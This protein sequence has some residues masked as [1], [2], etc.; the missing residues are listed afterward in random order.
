MSTRIVTFSGTSQSANL[1][2]KPADI[3]VATD[4]DY[5]N[6]KYI[7]MTDENIS[8]S[9]PKEYAPFLQDGSTA[10]NQ[11]IKTDLKCKFAIKEI[12]N[13]D[14]LAL[15]FGVENIDTTIAGHERLMID[16]NNVSIP[17]NLF[18]IRSKFVDG[19]DFEACI[20]KGQVMNPEDLPMGAATGATD[21]AN[22]GIEVEA[23]IDNDRVGNNLGYIDIALA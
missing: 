22:V 7:G 1:L 17:D 23:I 21:Y 10:F 19:R 11:V 5:A 18:V 2:I 13:I 15:A 6:A 16:S 12:G 20:W 8:V 9:I 4:G 14:Q 3:F